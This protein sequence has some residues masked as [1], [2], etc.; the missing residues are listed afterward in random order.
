VSEPNH[1]EIFEE[2]ETEALWKLGYDHAWHEVIRARGDLVPFLA[3][4]DQLNGVLDGT[5]EA[6]RLGWVA[7]RVDITD[8][9][10]PDGM[11]LD[12]YAARTSADERRSISRRRL[13]EWTS[14]KPDPYWQS[15]YIALY[16][17]KIERA[18]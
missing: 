14:L 8:A 4:D 11:T 7:G 3:A 15:I 1:L 16:A 18:R 5:S 2:A 9:L 17:C 13:E 6:L 12:E 10:L